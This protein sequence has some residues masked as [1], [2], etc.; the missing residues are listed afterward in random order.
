MR[1]PLPCII[2]IISIIIELHVVSCNE[3]ALFC[4]PSAHVLLKSTH[5]RF[6]NLQMV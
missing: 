3:H 5:A 4:E 6:G 1:L 2:N